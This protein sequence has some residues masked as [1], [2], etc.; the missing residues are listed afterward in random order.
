MKKFK[1]GILLFGNEKFK[2]KLD[3]KLPKNK[4]SPENINMKN[5]LDEF[6]IEEN[7]V[8]FEIKLEPKKHNG[9]LK[10]IKRKTNERRKGKNSR[11][12]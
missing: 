11:L 8:N 12:F 1:K 7:M 5:L 10:Y 6:I 4:I 3:K 2:N 9:I